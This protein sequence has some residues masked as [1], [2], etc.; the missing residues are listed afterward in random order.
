MRESLTDKTRQMVALAKDGNE[1]AVN[2]LWK[3]Y[4]ARVHWIMRLRMGGELRSKLESMD[5]VQDALLSALEDLGNFTYKNEG[6]F[7]R[8]LSTIAENRLRDNLDKLHAD[9]RDIR[10]ETRLDKR[11][12][13]TKGGFFRFP[14]PIE[15][16]TPSVIMSRKEEFDNL[17][18]AIDLLKPEYRKVIILAKIEGLSYKEIGQR[19][20]KSTDAVGMLLSRAMVALTSVFEG[21]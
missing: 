6:D 18:K 17:T 2:Q 7:L 20:D 3:V 11:V 19:L 14:G 9:K 15:A 12:S 5:L 4:G 21:D 16:T 13:T 1:S 8:W 10:K